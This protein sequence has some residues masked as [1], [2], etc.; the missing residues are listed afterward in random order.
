[1]NSDSRKRKCSAP[2]A[3]ADSVMPL[4][5]VPLDVPDREGECFDHVAPKNNHVIQ[6]KHPNTPATQTNTPATQVDSAFKTPPVRDRSFKAIRNKALYSPR[7]ARSGPSPS[8]PSS[9]VQVYSASL[10]TPRFTTDCI[11]IPKVARAADAIL[12]IDNLVTALS[13]HSYPDTDVIDPN[14]LVVKK[15]MRMLHNLKDS[16]DVL[17]DDK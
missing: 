15:I 12:N 8:T 10:Q 3:D 4:T 14:M 16:L 1:M 2:A 9:L 13:Q 7:F 5:Q 6:K 11:C 17:F